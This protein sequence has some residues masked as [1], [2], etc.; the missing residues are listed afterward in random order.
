[1][2]YLWKKQRLNKKIKRRGKA[3]DV[4]VG[5]SSLDKAAKRLS[6]LDK[7]LGLCGMRVGAYQTADLDIQGDKIVSIRLT[8]YF[9]ETTKREL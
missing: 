3:G 5:V 1:M 4:R 8:V 9:T 6:L 2:M 7:V